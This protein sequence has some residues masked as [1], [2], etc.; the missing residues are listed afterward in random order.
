MVI[1][2]LITKIGDVGIVEANVNGDWAGI[3][4]EPPVV[5]VGRMVDTKENSGT[6]RAGNPRGIEPVVV[7]IAHS[8][9]GV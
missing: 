4:M 7:G 1:A 8:S 2:G 6:R 3:A 5:A 9:R